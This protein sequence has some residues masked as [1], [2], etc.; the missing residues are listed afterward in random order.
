MVLQKSL[1]DLCDNV[2][3][4]NKNKEKCITVKTELEPISIHDNIIHIENTC[5]KRTSF[6]TQTYIY[7]NNTFLVIMMIIGAL[8]T[9]IFGLEQEIYHSEWDT[10]Y[11]FDL[12]SISHTFTCMSLMILIYLVINNKKMALILS[13]VLAFGFE[14]IEYLLAYMGYYPELYEE[15][16]GNR[17]ADLVFNLLGTVL[18]YMLISR[19]NCDQK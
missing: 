18:G 16:L 3:F 15:I 19:N 2:D 10:M 5:A 11:S 12:W 4:Y 1:H 7:N 17:I 13:N 14:I 8:I 6:L 9:V